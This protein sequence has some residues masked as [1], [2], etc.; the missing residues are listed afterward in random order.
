MKLSRS[1]IVWALAVLAA[2][3]LVYVLLLKPPPP[4]EEKIR[5]EVVRMVRAAEQKK[6]GDVMEPISLRFRSSDGLTRDELRGFLAGQLLRGQW[7]RIFLVD[8][9]V[10]VTSPDTAEMT[11]KFIFGRSDAKTL[12]DLAKESVMSSYQIDAQL[13]REP[14]DEWRVVKASYKAIDASQ[15]F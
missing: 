3:A 6:L 10:R 12:K 7:V 9:D 1:Q 4:P 13:E 11:G 8:L 15:F 5:Q 14:D 2:V